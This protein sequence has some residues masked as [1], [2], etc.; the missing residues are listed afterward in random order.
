MCERSLQI[1]KVDRALV[2]CCGPSNARHVQRGHGA[3]GRHGR[4]DA[5]DCCD[6][7][8][9]HDNGFNG[10]PGRNPAWLDR[11]RIARSESSAHCDGYKRNA[12]QRHDLFDLRDFAVWHVRID[13]DLRRRW[14]G[15]RNGDARGRSEL[16]HGNVGN[17][18]VVG[19]VGT[20]D[21]LRNAG[22]V[23][24]I[25]NVRLRLNQ[26]GFV[27]DSNIDVTDGA[28][29]P[30]SNWY[31]AG[32]YRDRQSRCQSASNRTDDERIAYNELRGDFSGANDAHRHIDDRKHGAGTDDRDHHVDHSGRLRSSIICERVQ[33]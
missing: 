16:W 11:N 32:I 10:W 23:G 15:I 5:L 25:G 20:V 8:A 26:H 31:S 18:D 13:R 28:G 7:A 4:A 6:F 19:D 3:N 1:G 9:W 27:F 33:P 17:V 29:R 14:N 12:K 24:I 30:G 21:N 22:D 2:D